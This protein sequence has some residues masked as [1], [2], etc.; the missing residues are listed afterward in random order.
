MDI[1]TD[2]IPPELKPAC[3]Q[4]LRRAR[5]LRKVDPVMAY[6][7]ELR[8]LGVEWTVPKITGN[9]RSCRSCVLM[10]LTSLRLFL[11]RFRQYETPYQTIT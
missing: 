11:R 5:E 3:E 10:Q 8:V 2:S 1:P 9:R 6:W 4:I 7:C